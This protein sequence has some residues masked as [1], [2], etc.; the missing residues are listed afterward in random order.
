MCWRRTRGVIIL[1]FLGLIP[2]CASLNKKE[3]PP[4]KMVSPASSIHQKEADLKVVF[5][6]ADSCF[7]QG[8]KAQ[9]L[10]NFEEA[11]LKFDEAID[12]ILHSGLNLEDFPRLKDL[13][14]D[15][16]SCI[17]EMTEASKLELEPDIKDELDKI[18]P[19]HPEGEQPLLEEE[20]TAEP[21]EITYDIPMSSHHKIQ[22]FIKRFQTERRDVMEESL[23]RSGKYLP[24]FRQIF[25]KQGLP[26]D[27]AYI[28]LIESSFKPFAYSRA[29]AKGMWQFV[30]GTALRYDLRIDWWID[31]RTDPEKSCLAAARYL[32]DLYDIFGDWYLAMA[33]YNAGENRVLRAVRKLKTIDFWKIASTQYLRRETRNYVPAILAA[34]HIAKNPELYG[35]S[36]E[37]EDP[38]L[39]SKV[40][41]PSCTD[42]QLIAEC[43]KTSLETILELN[44]ELRRL[45]TPPN[46]P[47]YNIKI[48]SGREEVFLANYSRIP[49]DKRVSWLQHRVRTGE[50]LS[51]IARR[52]RTTVSAL[53]QANNIKNRHFIRK[54]TLIVIPRGKP[55]YNYT[56]L[57]SDLHS[58]SRPPSYKRGQRIEYKVRRGDSLYRIALRFG[59]NTDSLLSW[60]QLSPKD[61]I[62]PGQKI[63]L[64]AGTKI[65]TGGNRTVSGGASTIITYRVR[66]GDTLYQIASIYKTTVKDI[67]RWNGLSPRDTI[68]PGD[69][70][71]IHCRP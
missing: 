67:C 25:E 39:Y 63:L 66:Q 52:Y 12:I 57:L 2:G 5:N 64:W 46:H 36:S 70:L 61:K 18:D 69:E 23:K 17:V 37:K 26:K 51:Q 34:I 14:D 6:K 49:P 30:V 56:S 35:F 68:Y 24:L 3:T 58:Q 47:N 32:K 50:T 54:G 1:I 29:H 44:P 60:N 21:E 8:K 48:P 11:F 55:K 19:E 43:A 27:L 4:P 71:T 7:R 10:G 13:F 65:D 40:A 33:A 22:A 15:I 62:Y 20:E 45:T 16:S 38:I 53:C 42:L 28:P 9:H 31:E 41:I 59:T